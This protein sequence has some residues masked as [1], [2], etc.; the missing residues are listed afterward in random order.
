VGTAAVSDEGRA[1]EPALMAVPR[2]PPPDTSRC[3]LFER[4]HHAHPVQVSLALKR[5]GDDHHYRRVDLVGTEVAEH[6][7]RDVLV[8]TLVDEAGEQVELLQHDPSLATRLAEVEHPIFVW[9][10][11]FGVLFVMTEQ[12]REA[13]GTPAITAVTDR[14]APCADA[15]A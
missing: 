13:M 11:E 10:D 3:G 1:G 7:G 9:E 14:L 12:G 2:V 15:S 6:D 8:L 5:A 4:G